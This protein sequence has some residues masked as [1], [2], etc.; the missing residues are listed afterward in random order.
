MVAR[1]LILIMEVMYIILPWPYLP[2]RRRAF[3]IR[4]YGIVWCWSHHPG[5][6]GCPWLFECQSGA[7]QRNSWVRSWQLVEKS[8]C[9]LSL[10][11]LF[12]GLARRFACC[13]SCSVF[14]PFGLTALTALCSVL[15]KNRRLV[16]KN[17]I[18]F[19]S[20]NSTFLKSRL[21]SAIKTGE[22][23]PE[24]LGLD[25]LTKQSAKL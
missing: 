8:R 7:K 16:R 5:N 20:T 3:L 22:S 9:I 24:E 11:N 15:L 10:P 14:A 19:L 23:H 25:G 6:P 4:L 18:L 12:P 17:N 2:S 13:Q 1:V 21:R